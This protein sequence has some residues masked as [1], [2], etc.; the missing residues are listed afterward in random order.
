MKK[1]VLAMLVVIGTL[2]ARAD[3]YHGYYYH[4]PHYTHVHPS[5]SFSFGVSPSFAAYPFYSYP[6]YSY[7]YPVYSYPAAYSAPAPYSSP[8][9]SSGYD[10]SYGYSRPNYAVGG[11]LLG[12]LTGGIIGSTIHNQGWEGAGIGAAAGLV[13]GSI[14]E[15]SARVQ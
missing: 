14:A 8:A 15:H 10:S 3:G 12:A 2:A 6:V 4:S 11:T 13:L 9:Y 7:S 1:I 5:V